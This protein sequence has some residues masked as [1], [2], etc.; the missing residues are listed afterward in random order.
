MIIVMALSLI[1]ILALLVHSV[2]LA[3]TVRRH[4]SQQTTTTAPQI[5]HD[6]THQPQLGVAI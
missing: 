3:V 2:V 6:Q 4:G 1:Q 5:E